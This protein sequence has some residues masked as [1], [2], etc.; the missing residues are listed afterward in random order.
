M[1]PT[2]AEPVDVPLAAPHGRH[3]RAACNCDGP[4]QGGKASV[5]REGPHRKSRRDRRPGDPDVPRLGI[6]TV[7]VYSDL[8]RDALPR[9]HGRRGL[10]PRGRDGGRE[11]PQ[12]RGHPRT[13]SSRAA[14]TRVHPGY[15]FFSE[16]TDFARAIT[17]ARRHLH[18]AA[19]RGHRGHGRQDQ[20]APGGR[21][22]RRGRCPGPLGAADL[23]RRGGG[24]RRPCTAG[25][26]RSRRPTAAAGAA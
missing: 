8:D 2:S 3:H 10:R 13:P 15:G 21:D 9:P 22:G 12:H 4:P 6:A 7:A 23:A 1:E 11:L 26:W 25:R 17:D 14:P 5:L 24:L 16:N 20:L 18:R 19:A